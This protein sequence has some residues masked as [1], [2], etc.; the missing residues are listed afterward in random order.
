MKSNSAATSKGNLKDGAKN[1]KDNARDK[2][3]EAFSNEIRIR[4]LIKSSHQVLNLEVK[5]TVNYI[6]Q[7]SNRNACIK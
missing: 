6:N 1:D 2:L 4:N 7:L 3:F 5:I